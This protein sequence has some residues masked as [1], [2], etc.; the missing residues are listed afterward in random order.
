MPVNE[1]GLK[2]DKE[3]VLTDKEGR[4]I[5]LQREIGYGK[6]IVHLEAGQPVRVTDIKKNIKL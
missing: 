4:Q 6:I 5:E 2:K 1:V 3:L